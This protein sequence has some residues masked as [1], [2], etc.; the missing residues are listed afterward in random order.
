MP[1]RSRCEPC[2]KSDGERIV[3][4][5]AEWAPTSTAHHREYLVEEA[6][7]HYVWCNV[8][9]NQLIRIISRACLI[10]MGLKQFA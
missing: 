5:R 1:Q 3:S 9:P 4:G 7:V 10:Q 2:H 6:E 8:L